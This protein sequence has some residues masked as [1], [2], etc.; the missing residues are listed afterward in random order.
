MPRTTLT[1]PHRSPLR[2]GAAS[3]GTADPV[4]QDPYR[5]LVGLDDAIRALSSPE[6]ITLTAARLLGGHLGAHRCAYAHV[7]DDQDSFH[8]TGNFT[9]GLPSAVGRYR[10][11]A[12][13]DDCLR[14]L[15]AGLPW[16]VADSETDLRTQPVVAMYRQISLRAVV[17]VPVLKAGRLVAAMA[18]H[19]SV[20]RPWTPADVE[21]LAG[22]ASRCWES[23]ERTRVTQELRE[24]EARYRTLLETISSVVWR[25]DGH[26]Q[27]VDPV[28]SWEDFTG[29]TPAEYRH[30]GWLDAIHPDDHERIRGIWRQALR[31]QRPCEMHY[32]LRRRDGVYR[33]M[34]VRA[35]PVPTER[36]RLPEWIGN[37]VDVTETRQAREWLETALIAGEVSTWIWH[38]PEGRV[39]G[40]RNLARLM[41][42]DEPAAWELSLTDFLGALDAPEGAFQAQYGLGS[43]SG[44]QR[45]VLARGRIERDGNGQ[46][47]R[48]PGVL[49]DVTDRVQAEQALRDSEERLREGLVAARMVVWDMDLA[50]RR[51]TFSANARQVFGYAWGEATTGLEAVHPDDVAHLKLAVQ[52]AIAHGRDYA[53]VVR[54]V[55]PDTGATLWTEVRGKVKYDAQGVARGL[56][57][58]SVDI[59]ERKRAEEELRAADRRKDEF[60]AMLAHEL[61]NPLA[62]IRNAAHLLRL[63]H[64][65]EPRVRQASEIIARQV[66]HMT[67]LVDDLLDMSR[68]TRGLVTLDCDTLDL[69]QVVA[70]AVE[71]VR[72]LID[73]RRHRLSLDLGAQA[74]PVLGDRMRLVQVVSNLLSNAAKYTP[75][76]GTI[77][78][79]ATINPQDVELTVR[80]NGASLEP[81]L[82]PHVF[83]LF[84]QGQRSPDRA[85]GGLGLGLALVKSLVGLHGGNVAVH[86]PGPGQGSTFSVWLPRAGAPAAGEPLAP[87]SGEPAAMR[88]GLQVLVVDDNADAA[89]S[90]AVLLQAG[91]HRVS[92]HGSG[93]GAL[94]HAS[95]QSFDV[96]LLDIGLPGMDGCELARRLR[97]LPHMGQAV[98]IALTGYGLADDRRR[99]QAA[100]FDH[101]LVKPVDPDALLALL[102]SLNAG[103]GH[104]EASQAG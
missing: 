10:F 76:G 97:A 18:L 85:Q 27:V 63:V 75:D 37:C 56:S 26:G 4:A 30:S 31:S 23:I 43:P 83:E 21:L 92:V 87:A 25:A 50:T 40:D 54:M 77:E 35:A 98:L 41:G 29:Q 104:L 7:D 32:R 91:G 81:E 94:L 38:I 15:H 100:G 34:Q 88:N 79:L 90:L 20:P 78:V 95:Q 3:T 6:E 48:M 70:S 49:L 64:S 19:Q 39:S 1:P 58:I 44:A 72:A 61:R 52:R 60:L 57:G 24:N 82:L 16:N 9:D 103:Q 93:P 17:C 71:Q 69:R 14:S 66:G 65:G 74:V 80:D 68:V 42:E 12:F 67:G 5:F 22:V 86:S 89:H 62:P 102:G 8:L 51:V 53:T 47:I 99:S 73:A 28:P 45:S 84:S 59:T 96:G 33:D 55:R 46:A 2:T 36:H 13:G 11:S 101:H